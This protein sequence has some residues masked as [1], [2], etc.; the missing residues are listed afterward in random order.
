MATKA[1]RIGQVVI[2]RVNSENR[3]D[4]ARELAWKLAGWSER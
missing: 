1:H 3:P 4:R 2:P